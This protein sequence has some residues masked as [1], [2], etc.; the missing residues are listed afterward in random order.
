[1]DNL[2]VLLTYK[3]NGLNHFFKE[4]LY[5]HFQNHYI[6]ASTSSIM[7]IRNGFKGEQSIVLP[8]AIIKLMEDDPLASSIYITDIGYYPKAWHHYRSRKKPIDQYVFIYCVN[9][10]GWFEVNDKRYDVK[11]N[12]Y[13]ILPAGISHT[14][15]AD[16][17]DPWTIYWIHF[18]GSLA[19]H[20]A[21]DCISPLN[22]T[23]SMA[24]RINT[25]I[26]LFEEIFNTL[27][28]SFAIEN[29]RY[30]MAT[31]QHYLASLRFIQ[32]YRDANDK[33]AH[34]NDIV[35]VV[36]HFIE[37]HLTLKEIADFSGLSP[38]RLS[39]V[40][41][42]RTGHSP[43]NYFNFM[44]MRKA[45][46]FLDNTDLKL[47]QISLKLGIDD[48]YYFSRLFSHIMGVSPKAYRNRNKV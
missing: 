16:E 3:R 26:N 27:K 38:S 10:K 12:Q 2:I 25:R 42:E 14:Y 32:Q 24:S 15:A 30:A 23:P 28:S 22:V 36:T 19:K 18:Y 34:G 6:C 37:R 45:C 8:Q 48:P 35:N 4:S 47:N 46:N 29:I 13:F 21:T 17:N 9:G 44:K 1:M 20:Y 7:K 33:T 40:F 5:L 31:F 11:T 41:K 43:L 39:T